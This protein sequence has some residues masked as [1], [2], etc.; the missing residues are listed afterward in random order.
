MDDISLCS[1]T[2]H[3][4]LDVL[5]CSCKWECGDFKTKTQNPMIL[6]RLTGGVYAPPPGICAGRVC[7][8]SLNSTSVHCFRALSIVDKGGD[9]MWHLRQDHKRSCKL[10]SLFRML[11]LRAL[12][13]RIS[14]ATPRPPSCEEPKPRGEVIMSAH[15]LPVSVFE[16]PSQDMW[17]NEP[18]NESGSKPSPTRPLSADSSCGPRDKR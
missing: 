6:L 17:M 8:N 4:Q 7:F 11:M 16:S 15:W 3:G 1:E 12:S 2:F 5:M 13:H 9:G 14:W 10:L 18:R